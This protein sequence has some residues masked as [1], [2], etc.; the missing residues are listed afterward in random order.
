MG[1]ILGLGTDI[2]SIARIEPLLRKP[3]FLDRILSAQ[4]QERPITAS[5]VAGRWAAKEAIAK[6]VS[7][8]LRWHDVIIHTDPAGRPIATVK[9]LSENE[10][11]WVSISHDRTHAVAVAI[12][13][14]T[15]GTPNRT[16]S[17]ES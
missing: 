6:A 3:T 16:E 5:Y 4:E 2:V 11:V 1:E 9:G 8:R 15:H 17:V 12:W 13:Q 10:Q 14:R 7:I